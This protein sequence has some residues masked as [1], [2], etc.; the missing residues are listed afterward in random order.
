MVC[1]ASIRR[2]SKRNIESLTPYYYHRQPLTCSCLFCLLLLAPVR[3]GDNCNKEIA[4]KVA[5]YYDVPFSTAFEKKV[6]VKP[7]SASYVSK[8]TYTLSALFTACVKNGVIFHNPVANATKPRIGE[9]DIPPYLDNTTIPIFLDTLAEI[10]IDNA[11]RVSLVL[12][13]MLG[14]RSGEARGLRWCDVDFQNNV[15]SVEKMSVIL[16]TV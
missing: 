7:L 4:E 1:T 8:I 16:L 15:V 13:L 10:D 14:L 3:R 6:E 12:M 5:K 11:I 9:K 2:T